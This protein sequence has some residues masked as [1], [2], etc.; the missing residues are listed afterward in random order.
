MVVGREDVEALTSLEE[1]RKKVKD[2]ESEVE[3]VD[4]GKEFAIKDTEQELN[5]FYV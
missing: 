5:S 1:Y 4:V 2:D 3:S